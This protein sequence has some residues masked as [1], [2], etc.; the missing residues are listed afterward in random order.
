MPFF[1]FILEKNCSPTSLGATDSD[2]KILRNKIRYYC[3]NTKVW[4]NLNKKNNRYVL[5]D[6]KLEKH[7]KFNNKVKKIIFCL[8]P[9]IGVGDAIEYGLA[10]KAIEKKNIF[11]KVGI[12]FSSRYSSILS[13]FINLK[14]FYPDFIR[15]DQVNEYDGLFHFTSEINEL[16]LQKYQR[17]NIEEC[18]IN[19]FNVNSYRP[20]NINIKKNISRISIFPIARSPI[21]TLSAC[22]VNKI[23]NYLIGKNYSVDIVLDNNS[24]ISEIFAKRKRSHFGEIIIPDNLEKL[25]DYIKNI[26]FGIFCDSGPLHLSKIY[27]KNGLL[28]STSVDSKKLLNKK[29]N[30]IFYNSE[31]KSKYCKA[32]CDLTNIINF[33][34]RHGCYDTLK[35]TRKF[36]MSN[37]KINTLNR[38]NLV[39]SYGYYTENS[40][41]CVKS[42]NFSKIEFLLKQ[43]LNL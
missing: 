18:I 38:G 30:I 21:R 33:K 39:N 9:S 15:D 40:V 6:L 2:I 28:I 17:A 1:S 3:K 19:Y 20:S 35:K 11:K 43:A 29:D 36:I 16:K 31:Y 22:L 32:P 23:S 27:R 4:K 24:I 25:N 42:I 41:G 13:Q 37:S 34:N 26:E 12:A 10:I 7:L 8:P 14:N 5:K